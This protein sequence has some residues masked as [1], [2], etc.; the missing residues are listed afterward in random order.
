MANRMLRA[1]VAAAVLYGARR[2]FR[3]WGTTKEESAGTLVG[4]ELVAPPVLRATEGVSIAAPADAVW[5]WLV[6]M[7]Q[8][9]GGLYS[10]ETLEA[11][12]GLDYHNADV[13]HPEWQHLAVGDSVRLVPK[14]WW[15]LA[16]GVALRVV[17]VSAPHTLVLRAAPPELP[18]ETVWSFHLVP[19]WDDKC[20]LLV[21]SRLALRHPGEVVLAELLGPVRAFT[22]R[23]ILL[24][25]KRRAE[26]CAAA[27]EN[28]P[29]DL[30]SASR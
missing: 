27:T 5:P 23:G 3:D 15:G 29:A 4:D 10:F 22:T 11:A 24:G 6:Q 9:R 21:R 2:Y 13:I 25:I 1:G 14:G 7:G 17:Q 19:H 26:R 12:A 16:D 28:A 20:R 30:R 18:W 8:D